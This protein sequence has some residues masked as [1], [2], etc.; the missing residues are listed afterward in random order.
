MIN[1][2]LF[3]DTHLVR[4]SYMFSQW[5]V[6]AGV[7][8]VFGLVFAPAAT[9]LIPGKEGWPCSSVETRRPLSYEGLTCSDDVSPWSL[10]LWGLLCHF[11]C[12]TTLSAEASVPPQAF[13]EDNTPS[14]TSGLMST[15][16]FPLVMANSRCPACPS[17]TWRVAHDGPTGVSTSL[18]DVRSYGLILRSNTQL[19]FVLRSLF[20]ALYRVLTQL[21]W[22]FTSNSPKFDASS[23]A[24]NLLDRDPNNDGYI[25]SDDDS[26]DAITSY[27]G[28][29]PSSPI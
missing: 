19:L 16:L 12:L 13:L 29:A 23:H 7:M 22:A 25:S 6:A 27:A 4:Y 20:P 10:N 3:A 14:W 9:T 18:W 2:I 28:S 8:L 26:D 21:P 24:D 11:T 15:V 17:H 1:H 5:W